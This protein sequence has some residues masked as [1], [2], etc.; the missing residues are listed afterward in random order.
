MRHHLCFRW[1]RFPIREFV[2]G[3]DLLAAL[4]EGAEELQATSD[5]YAERCR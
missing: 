5:Q 1:P 4:A 2:S 3:T